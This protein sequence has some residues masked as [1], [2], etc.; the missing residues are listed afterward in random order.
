MLFGARPG[1]GTRGFNDSDGSAPTPN[2]FA[3]F[4]GA[5][6]VVFARTS[7]ASGTTLTSP[8]TIID[9]FN[10]PAN[11]LITKLPDQTTCVKVLE[12]SRHKSNDTVSVN[13]FFAGTD[14]GLYVFSKKDGTG[15]ALTEM[16]LTYLAQ[17]VWRH[18][19]NIS[20]SIT[21]VKTLG[22][23]G[24]ALDQG[25]L[26]VVTTEEGLKSTV[27]RI[28][29]LASVQ[30]TFAN[31]FVLA[32]SGIGIFDDVILFTGIRPV[33]ISFTGSPLSSP[34]ALD[35]KGEE[36]V[37]T[38]N[39]GLFGSTRIDP[40][41]TSFTGVNTATNQIEAAWARIPDGNVTTFYGISGVYTL[42]PTTVWPFSVERCLWLLHL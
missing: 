17:G 12:Y 33:I 25:G 38:T 1:S 19:D 23:I 7:F 37:L 11:F 8:Q 13:Y 29:I 24:A 39:Y 28:P 36:L 26:Y 18:I 15:F 30:A 3:L 34:P 9:N 5:G 21:D 40:S 20:G 31:N 4:G 41:G 42:I 10:A 16:D 22:S 6:T 14:Q 35:L 27:Y 2:R 32:Q